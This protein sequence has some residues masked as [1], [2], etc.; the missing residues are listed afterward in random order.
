MVVIS[1]YL[2]D[3]FRMFLFDLKKKTNDD[4]PRFLY[5]NN[6]KDKNQLIT[7]CFSNDECLESCCGLNT[8]LRERE[9]KILQ[10]YYDDTST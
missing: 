5:K 2:N 10:K 3:K 6:P 9:G 4:S 8:I 1:Y 7:Y